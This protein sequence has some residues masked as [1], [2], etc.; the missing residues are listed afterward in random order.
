SLLGIPVRVHPMFWAVSV[1]LGLGGNR[2]AGEILLWVGAVFVSIVVHEMGHALSARAHGWQPWITLYGMGGLASYQ[3]TYRSPRSQI[4]ITA[5]GPLAGFVF[6]AVVLAFVAA[7]GH[8]VKFD[9]SF[10]MIVPVRWE[11]YPKYLAN[12]LVF[13]LLFI[14]IFWG[15]VSVLP[16]SPLD[17]GQISREV[18]GLV[19]PGDSLRMSLWISVFTAAVVAVLALTRLNDKY[20]AILFAYLAYTSYTTLDGYF[21]SGRGRG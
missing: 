19:N 16:V 20:V 18:L 6:A 7:S 10:D 15:L 4:L 1:L 12:L 11:P 3:P 21:G 14:N 5:A 17:G 8:R 9:P 2:D 13:D